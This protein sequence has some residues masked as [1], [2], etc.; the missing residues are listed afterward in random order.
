MK[1]ETRRTLD[2]LAAGAARQRSHIKRLSPS[3]LRRLRD[4]QHEHYT[5]TKE[6]ARARALARA[7]ADGLVE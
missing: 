6:D 7:Y 2:R 1:R 5:E 4:R 3:Q